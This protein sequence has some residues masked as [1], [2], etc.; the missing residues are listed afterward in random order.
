MHTDSNHFKSSIGLGHLQFVFSCFFGQLETL[1]PDYHV[2]QLTVNSVNIISHQW[3]LWC[4]GFGL[5]IWFNQTMVQPNQTKP[6]NWSIYHIYGF[7]GVESAKGVSVDMPHFVPM[8][9]MIQK[10]LTEIR[11][12][13]CL[14]GKCCEE[15]LAQQG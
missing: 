4:W 11:I 1:S 14:P 15:G 13:N 2:Y 5:V 10:S 7:F 8:V 12:K 3:V 6:N 9:I